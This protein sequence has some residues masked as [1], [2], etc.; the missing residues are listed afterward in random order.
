M[1]TQGGSGFVHVCVKLLFTVLVVMHVVMLPSALTIF[2]ALT[3]GAL[4]LGQVGRLIMGS[5]EGAGLLA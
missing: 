3:Y 2:A 5:G 1:G 4:V